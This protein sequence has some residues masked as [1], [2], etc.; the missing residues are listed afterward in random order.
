[1]LK[2]TILTL[3][4]TLGLGFS[5]HSFGLAAA[6]FPALFNFGYGL[7]ATIAFGG[8]VVVKEY[9]YK[10]YGRLKSAS[11][12]YLAFGL[13]M[14]AKANVVQFQPL[15]LEDSEQLNLTS[16]EFESYDAELSR[17]NALIE[18]A[19]LLIAQ[20]SEEK[21]NAVA[22]EFHETFKE[23]LSPNTLSAIQKIISKNMII[24]E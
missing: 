23:E 13:L 6:A 11:G 4:L 19:N 9:S 17:V 2:K 7:V 18:E 5:N 15:S 3:V 20:T 24:K 16:S 14:D 8:V 12:M 21:Q 10:Y 22:I 1:M